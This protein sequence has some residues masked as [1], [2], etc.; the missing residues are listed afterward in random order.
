MN[1]TKVCSQCQKH[2]P[3]EMFS[4]DKT[5]KDGRYSICKLC[6][7]IRYQQG[8]RERIR[9]W[10]EN[11]PTEVREYKNRY[12]KKPDKRILKTR[13]QTEYVRRNPEKVAARNYCCKRRHKLM[14]DH[15]QECGA[16]ENL[17][18]H[19]LSYSPNIWRTLCRECHSRIPAE[20]KLP[21]PGNHRFKI[22]KEED[23]RRGNPTHAHKHD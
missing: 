22:I 1:K 11:H 2:Q 4:R 14:L 18:F 3:T 9:A 19:H 7:R 20:S 8:G 16:I 5:S 12:D 23:L 10:Q 15:C 17:N 13:L 21:N 6:C